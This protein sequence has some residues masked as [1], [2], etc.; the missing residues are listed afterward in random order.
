MSTLREPCR[1]AQSR[2]RAWAT[3]RRGTA[4]SPPPWAVGPRFPLAPGESCPLDPSTDRRAAGR[5]WQ[6]TLSGLLSASLRCGAPGRCPA[7]PSRVQQGAGQAGGPRA[8]AVRTLTP[9]TQTDC[10][11]PS[12]P[13]GTFMIPFQLSP[14][15]TWKSVRKAM[16]KFSK[17]ACRLMP[18]HGFSSLQTK[19][20]EEVSPVPLQSPLPHPPCPGAS[21]PHLRIPNPWRRPAHRQRN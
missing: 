16:P 2:P 17:V 12:L 21:R 14:V 8:L 1:P 3:A 4:C 7:V 6:R 10:S 9:R 15:E 13:T 5:G 11:L 18:S 20:R 19:R